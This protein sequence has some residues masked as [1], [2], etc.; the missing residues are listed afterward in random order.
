MMKSE[1]IFK[2]KPVFEWH[3][4]KKLLKGAFFKIVIWKEF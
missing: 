4:K 2:N 1:M 3:T